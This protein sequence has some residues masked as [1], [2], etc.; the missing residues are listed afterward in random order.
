MR[1][2]N[3]IPLSTKLILL[4]LITTAVVLLVAAAVREKNSVLRMYSLTDSHYGHYISENGKSSF[5]SYELQD[6]IRMFLNG[7]ISADEFNY[8]IE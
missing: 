8:A 4:V 5:V 7:E 6:Y 2:R 3:E 1:N